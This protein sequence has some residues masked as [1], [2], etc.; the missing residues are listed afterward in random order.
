MPNW[1]KISLGCLEELVL[2]NGR[3]EWMELESNCACAQVGPNGGP[4]KAALDGTPLFFWFCLFVCFNICR[5]PQLLVDDAAEHA[6]ISR[7]DRDGRSSV[8]LLRESEAGHIVQVLTLKNAN[9]VGWLAEKG[10][11]Q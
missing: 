5:C 11:Y 10:S 4:P 6:E 2:C 3:D 7:V 9:K 8:W 1:M